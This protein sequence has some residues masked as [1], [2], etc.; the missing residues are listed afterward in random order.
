MKPAQMPLRMSQR[1][2][3]RGLPVPAIS[4]VVNGTPDFRVVDLDKW[5]HLANNRL[6]SLCGTVL[7]KLMWF[8]GGD[9]C[10]KLRMFF[11]LPV[12]EDCGLYAF[13]ICPY[14]ALTTSEYSKRSIEYLESDTKV[15]MN[16]RED[17]SP[18]R[19]QQLGFAAATSYI[20]GQSEKGQ[21]LVQ[22]SEWVRGPFW[23]ADRADAERYEQSR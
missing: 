2:L 4:T 15:L 17:I 9:G 13:K 5:D 3:F 6:C 22:A 16:Y 11:D 20:I 21:P 12:H 14:L 18:T 23:F 1:P 7:R 10:M 8:I 19:P